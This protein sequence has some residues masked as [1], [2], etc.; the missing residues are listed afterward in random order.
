MYDDQD[1]SSLAMAN[2]A[3]GYASLTA[4]SSVYILIYET[5]NAQLIYA[6]I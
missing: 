3:Y 6:C 1:G 2:A 4:C 5:Q